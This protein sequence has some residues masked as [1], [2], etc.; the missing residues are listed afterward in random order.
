MAVVVP[1]PHDPDAETCPW[2]NVL[3][4]EIRYEPSRHDEAGFSGHASDDAGSGNGK[5]G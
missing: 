3:E 2:L 1:V 5:F 4:Y